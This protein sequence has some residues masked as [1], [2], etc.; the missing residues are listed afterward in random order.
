MQIDMVQVL[1]G[2]R[3]T[4]PILVQTVFCEFETLAGVVI[5]LLADEA[6]ARWQ[7]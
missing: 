4:H 7:K 2:A 1:G 6:L 3:A 5:I